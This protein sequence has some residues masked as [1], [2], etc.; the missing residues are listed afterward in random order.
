MKAYRNREINILVATDVAARGIDVKDIEAIFNYDVPN[1]NEY[2]VHR[3][4]RT[5]RAS[6][7]GTA[8][9]FATSAD[10][11]RIRELSKFADSVIEEYHLDGITDVRVGGK[12]SE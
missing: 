7:T 11:H 5:A 4:G 9:T 6:K 8:Y 2:Y 3:I 10:Y 1:N 12:K